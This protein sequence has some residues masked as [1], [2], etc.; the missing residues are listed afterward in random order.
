MASLR[1]CIAVT[2]LCALPLWGASLEE[3]LFRGRPVT[4]L[5]DGTK[6]IF[7][8]DILL[9]HVSPLP[10]G[11]GGV[12]SEAIG[13]AYPQY[14]WPANTQGVAEIPYVITSAADAA[15]IAALSAFNSTFTGVIQFVPRGTQADYVNFD[16]DP[17]DLSG[18]CES[19]V[20]HVGGEQTTSG[21]A[22]CSLGTLLHEM[23]HVVG[24]YHEQSRPDRN[25]YITVNFGNVIK[26]SESNFDQLTDNFQDL[27]L[28]D[29]ASIME[30][31]PFAFSRNGGPVIETIPPGMPLSNQTGYTAADIDGVKR[32][33]GKTPKKV[34]VTSNP[35]GLSV[36]VDGAAVTTPQTFSWALKSTH[37]CPWVRR[38]RP[39]R[40]APTCTDDGTTI[41]RHRT[42]SP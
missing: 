24:L 36:T 39:W 26:G 4:Y 28:F 18:Q 6:R 10:H 9:D 33:Y 27:G 5:H 34:T 17:N 30:Y 15:A 21:S 29:Y 37:T 40:A 3:G 22:S 42:A 2:L 7:E 12:Q 25:T 23:G 13:V 19:N 31:I 16:F 38:H 1:L 41:P 35:P 11:H 8:G 32:L 20:G 14:L